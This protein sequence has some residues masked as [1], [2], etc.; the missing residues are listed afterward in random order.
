VK[1]AGIILAAGESSRMGTDKALLRLG[2]STFLERAVGL[3]LP[4]VEPVI[5]VLGHHATRIREAMGAPPGVE[6]VVNENYAAG[7]LS[8]LQTGIQAVPARSPAALVTLVDHPLVA[9]AT[10]DALL[11]R[12]GA[13]LVIPRYRN[14]RGHPVLFSRMLLDELLA[15]EPPATAKDVVNRHADRAVY[16]DLED[17]GV[18]R[19]IDTPDDY[20]TLD[21]H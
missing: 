14:R 12:S 7:Q 3:F 8:S 2:D 21:P 4:R 1:P 20:R 11:A 19:D 10:L 18:L 16:L 9:P 15:L 17:P 5:V 6:F 13:A